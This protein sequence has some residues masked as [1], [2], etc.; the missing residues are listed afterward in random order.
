[1]MRA[2]I[3]AMILIAGVMWWREGFYAGSL[4]QQWVL[5][6]IAVYVVES[7]WLWLC[8][9][10]PLVGWFIFGF[11]P[12]TSWPQSATMTEEIKSTPIDT[13]KAP[14]RRATCQR[15]SRRGG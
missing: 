5:I 12:R 11:L 13:E 7:V 3:L 2:F 10:H 9:R 6:G 8:R 15:A 1:M 14:H 4:L